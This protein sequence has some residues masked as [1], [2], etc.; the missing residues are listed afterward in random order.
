MIHTLSLEH[1]D[2]NIK[3][4][5]K[6]LK[7][8]C[9]LLTSCRESESP[10]LENL[11]IV[12]K[13]F[14]SSEFNSYIGNFQGK[15][16]DGTNID[17]DNFMRDTIM[18]YESLVED[19][20]WDTKSEKD[21]NILAI[22]KQIQEIKILFAKQSNYQDINKNINVGNTMFNNGGSSWKTSAPTSDDSK[23]LKK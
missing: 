12:L 7:Y 8:Y 1:F 23:N 9:K 10:I 11:L 2:N 16:D 15:Y 4:L 6:Y 18:K 3:S 5:V 20:Q 14:T 21:G 22:T 19:G 13:K 17:L